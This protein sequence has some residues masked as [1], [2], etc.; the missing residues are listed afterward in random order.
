MYAGS[1]TSLVESTDK[2]LYCDGSEVS[3]SSYRALYRVIGTTYGAGNGKDTF[4]LPDLRTRFPLGSTTSSDGTMASGGSQTHTLTSSELP[5]HTHDQG[6]LVT[7]TNGIHSHSI[8]DPGHNHGGQT[9]SAAMKSGGSG[10][11][12][13]GSGSDSGTHQH[14][15]NSG[16]TSITIQNNGGHTHTITGSTGSAGSG[17]SFN[18]MPPY[19]TVHYIIR[20]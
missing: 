20:T 19:Q 11:S 16:T 14:N 18:I 13:G 5:A 8:N 7:Q 6:T 10:M 1:A 17:Q 9:G 3:R 15:I 4:N 2:W 12:G